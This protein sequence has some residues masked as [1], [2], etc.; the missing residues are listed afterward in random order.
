MKQVGD[1]EYG[2]I[3]NVKTIWKPEEINSIDQILLKLLE[4][5]YAMEG[6]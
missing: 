5:D 6:K 1:G 2:R 4:G 3:V